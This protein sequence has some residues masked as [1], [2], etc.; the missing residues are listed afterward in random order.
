[1]DPDTVIPSA[2][3]KEGPPGHELLSGDQ[4]RLEET[5]DEEARERAGEKESPEAWRPQPM[6]RPPGRLDADPPSTRT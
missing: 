2:A 5:G 3:L 6:L 4:V 1:M